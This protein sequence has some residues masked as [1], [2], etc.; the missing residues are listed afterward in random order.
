MIKVIS[1]FSVDG[2]KLYGKEFLESYIKYWPV[3]IHVYLEGSKKNYPN[4]ISDANII[5]HDLFKIP[6]CTATLEAMGKFQA[7][8]GIIS[9]KQDYRF[10]IYR[11]A[12]KIFAQ[13]DA[14]TNQDD[15]FF[16]LDADTSFHGEVTEEWLRDLF[17]ESI[18]GK[19]FMVYQGRPK[20]HSCASF[21]GWDPTHEQNVP[22]W[23]KYFELITTG[24]FLLLPEWHDSFILDA[25]RDGMNIQALNLTLDVTQDGPVNVFD[26]VFKGKG[27]HF[28]GNLKY[29]P[30]RYGQLI[31][32]VRKLQPK[33]IIEIGTWDGG[34]AIEMAGATSDLNYI[35]FD[36]FEN[37]TPE[38]DKEEMNV[39][40]HHQK[41]AVLHKLLQA[42]ISAELVKG[43][44][45]ETLPAWIKENPGYQADLI[46]I[47]GGHAVATIESDLNN[48]LKAIKPG[49]TIVMDDW[50]EGPIDIEQFGCNKV[51]EK[52]GL[53]YEIL[54]IADPVKDGGFTKMAVIYDIR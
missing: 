17:K 13:C 22:F 21:V 42:G 7:M 16:W 49:G 8:S 20:W 27:K 14:A 37:A 1:S 41:I 2:Y 48:A 28:K 19:P 52:S 6:G 35:G 31:E 40:P 24:T 33:R 10:N 53:K 15:L 46:Y 9:G 25:L 12:R 3:P 50:Y 43:N 45:N 4:L 34:R 51:L 5:Y 29:G 11:F 32:I 36:L 54:P 26:I 23:T 44:T 39:K 18:R 30:R 47:D 38:T